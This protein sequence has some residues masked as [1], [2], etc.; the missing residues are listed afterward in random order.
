MVQL[1]LYLPFSLDFI[2]EKHTSVPGERSLTDK[3][4]VVRLLSVSSWQV[5]LA[6]AAVGTE[7]ENQSKGSQDSAHDHVILSKF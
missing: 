3:W 7:L 5:I 1:H 2:K 6:K 4:G